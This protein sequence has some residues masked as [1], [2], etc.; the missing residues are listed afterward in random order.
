VN[1]TTPTY[2]LETPRV[3]SVATGR[4][5][6]QTPTAWNVRRD[7]APTDA[8]LRS[9]VHGLEAST[10]QG[11]VNEHLGVT[12]VLAAQLVHQGTGAVVATYAPPAFEAVA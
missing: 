6:H 2:R 3:Y 8:N 5:V 12:R 11:G 9:Y 7:G 10:L 1:S 4:L